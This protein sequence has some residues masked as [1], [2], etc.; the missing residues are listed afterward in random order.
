MRNVIA[1]CQIVLRVVLAW[2][3]SIGPSTGFEV[4]VPGRQDCQWHYPARRE[5]L[6]PYAFRPVFFV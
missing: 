1:L 5:R 6:P 2:R 3:K 4:N